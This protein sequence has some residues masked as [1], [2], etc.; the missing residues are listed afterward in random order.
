MMRLKVFEYTGYHRCLYPNP[1][2]EW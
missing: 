1:M 2:V